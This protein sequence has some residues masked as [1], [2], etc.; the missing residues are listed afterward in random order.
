MTPKGSSVML[1]HSLY[2]QYLNRLALD[3]A[4]RNKNQTCNL[5]TIGIGGD[6]EAEK[7]LLQ[8]VP[9]CSAFGADPVRSAGAPFSHI[10]LLVEAA[11]SDSTG[12]QNASVLIDSNYAIKAVPTIEF[13]KFLGGSLKLNLV[14]FLFL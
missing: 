3:F 6:I 12:V 11:I 13:E 2:F 1:L 9:N 5:V 7:K 4:F 8:Q 14:D 10:G